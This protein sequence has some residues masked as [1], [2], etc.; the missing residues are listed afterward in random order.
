VDESTPGQDGG[1]GKNHAGIVVMATGLFGLAAAGIM[2]Y[3][4]YSK[5]QEYLQDSLLLI[6]GATIL[7]IV[8]FILGVYLY[9]KYPEQ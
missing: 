3:D 7:G 1:Q 9:L 8:S 2:Y 6:S 5:G 4:A